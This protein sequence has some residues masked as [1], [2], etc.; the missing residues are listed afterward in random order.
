MKLGSIVKLKVPCLG[1]PVGSMGVCYE[2][3]S[4]GGRSFIFQNGNYDGFSADEQISFLNEIGLSPK[5]SSYKF[6][7]V[8]SLS[9]DFR[10]GFFDSPL[11]EWN[12]E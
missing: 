10:R 11:S 7:N 12:M 4:N 1:N 2:E 8:L 6:K 9:D 5:I 3:Y